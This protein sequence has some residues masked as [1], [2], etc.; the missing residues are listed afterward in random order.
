MLHNAF[1][2]VEKETLKFYRCLYIIDIEKALPRNT[3]SPYAFQEETPPALK[4]QAGFLL[5]LNRD[6]TDRNE[7]NQRKKVV[8]PHWHRPLSRAEI[9]RL[10]YG[11]AENIIA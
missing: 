4:G 5:C 1:Q 2:I 10:P 7:E 9:D 3:V 8:W 11:N 6:D